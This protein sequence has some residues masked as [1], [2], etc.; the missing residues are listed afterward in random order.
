MQIT[1]YGATG[2]FGRRLV[3]HLREREHSVIAAHRGIGV[4]TYAGEGVTEA[5]EGSEVLVD[6][7]N[8]MTNNRH[9][10][11]DFFSRSSRSIALAAAENP[12]AAMVCLSIAFRPEVAAS[13][14]LGYYQAKELQERVYR[15][16]VPADQL[17]MFRST[18][19]FELVESLTFTAG[20]VAFVPRMRVQALSADEAARMMAEAIDAGERGTLEVAGPEVSDFPTIAGRIAATNADADSALGTG[21]R[22]SRVSK[23]VPIPLPGPM[24]TNGLIPDSPRLSAVTVD[25]WLRAH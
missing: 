11:L 2:T 7:V 20:P 6:C 12:G 5:G 24:S 15:R 16:L 1:V 3:A 25:D 19:W 23:I 21:T 13:K 4:D 18:Q 14:L 17:L 9:K 22:W 8:H 10:A